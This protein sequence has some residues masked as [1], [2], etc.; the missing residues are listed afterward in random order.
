MK[1]AKQPRFVK[2][3]AAIA[4]WPK[5][6]NGAFRL[7]HVLKSYRSRDHSQCNPS[8]TTLMADMGATRMSVFRWLK[9]L[10]DRDLIVRISSGNSS[11]NYLISDDGRAPLIAE[12]LIV[13]KR[14]RRDSIKR[15]TR[16]RSI[17]NKAKPPSNVIPLP[18]PS[19]SDS[20]EQSPFK[21]DQSE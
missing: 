16:T 14:I 20:S 9:E 21:A 3:Y 10:E 11:N 7:L 8:A 17:R 18:P 15:G 12:Q 4:K 1:R 2:C 13:S 5:L 6:S 19:D